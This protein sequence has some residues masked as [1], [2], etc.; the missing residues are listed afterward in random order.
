MILLPPLEQL[1][2]IGESEK[3]DGLVKV[4]KPT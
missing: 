2:F 3:R 4:P 1:V